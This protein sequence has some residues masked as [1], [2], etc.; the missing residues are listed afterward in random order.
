MQR[1]GLVAPLVLTSALGGRVTPAT[2][3]PPAGAWRT[4]DGP[5]SIRLM[6]AQAPGGAGSG[7]AAASASVPPEQG[8]LGRVYPATWLEPRSALSGVPMHAPRPRLRL[9]I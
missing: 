7:A 2:D 4:A 8:A 9:T 5:G 6:L 3:Q 1:P